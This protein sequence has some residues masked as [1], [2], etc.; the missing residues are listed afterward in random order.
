[1]LIAD[2][3]DDVSFSRTSHHLR[4]ND[5]SYFDLDWR[6]TSPAKASSVRGV[7]LG[8]DKAFK[9]ESGDSEG[10]VTLGDVNVGLEAL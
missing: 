4:A 1:M 5:G 2:D 3:D 9:E 8:A 7:L 10:A 6:A